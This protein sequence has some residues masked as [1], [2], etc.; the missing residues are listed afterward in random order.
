MW[1]LPFFGNRFADVIKW[2]NYV[3]PKCYH[4]CSFKG[5]A[6]RDDTHRNV[7]THSELNRQGILIA[8]R[9]C[10][11]HKQIV[12]KEY[13]EEMTLCLYLD[14]AQWLFSDLGLLFYKYFS[15]VLSQ[16]VFGNL[17]QQP[18]KVIYSSFSDFWSHPL[19][20]MPFFFLFIFQ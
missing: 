4:K 1:T 3:E 12:S 5:K 17:L 16:H 11:G 15:V 14:L 18:K 6:E 9:S 2:V 7:T 10:K 13:S 8:T 19:C 20:W